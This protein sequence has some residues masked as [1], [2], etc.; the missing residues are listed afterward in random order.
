MNRII[1][2][3]NTDIWC[4]D[5]NTSNNYIFGADNLCSLDIIN[6]C[7]IG[8]DVF[9][10]DPP[11]NTKKHFSYSDSHGDHAE[12]SIFMRSRLEII[13]RLTRSSGFVFISID[14]SELASTITLCNDIFGEDNFIAN[15]VWQR[16]S[17]RKN[18]SKYFSV[19]HEYILV[20]AKDKKKCNIRLLKRDGCDN[21]SNP[22]NDIRGS[23]LASSPFGNKIYH[24]DYVVTSPTGRGY[25][26]P[27]G[28]FWRY[29]EKTMLEKIQN[30]ELVW[31]S[32]TFYVK[33]YLKDVRDGYIPTTW[34]DSNFAGDNTSACKEIKKIFNGKKVIDYP[35]PT[36]LI[37]RI[38]EIS[39]PKDGV[40]CDCF[41]GSGTTGQAIFDMNQS[42]GGNRS[43]IL[44]QK[45]E[46]IRNMPWL[47]E[48]GYNNMLDICIARLQ[49]ARDNMDLSFFC[50]DF[51]FNIIKKRQ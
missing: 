28:K 20:Y 18:M 11:Y 19:N 42:D 33:R 25:T 34:W 43:F 37:K 2:K 23:W 38:L 49:H 31:D 6:N 35:K 36:S 16:F 3:I 22:D 4:V 26:R 41:A 29:S 9:Y 40:V 50:G 15:I 24:A 45:E 1:D 5:D 14:D 39:C 12:W 8:V 47:K 17:G 7:G 46:E 30:D 32:D 27:D 44:M 48:M 10:L 21:Y 51:N 13:Q